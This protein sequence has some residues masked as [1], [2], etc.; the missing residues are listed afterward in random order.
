MVTTSEGML[1]RVTKEMP[2]DPPQ[3]E[4]DCDLE[5]AAACYFYTGRLPTLPRLAILQ[6]VAP[7]DRAIL[8]VQVGEDRPTLR[9][10]LFDKAARTVK[11]LP[12]AK[13]SSRA[14]SPWRLEQ[15]EIYGLDGDKTYELLLADEKGALI[16]LREF[17]AM[18]TEPTSFKFAMVAGA[19]DSAAPSAAAGWKTLFARKPALIF[20]LGDL[21][22]RDSNGRSVTDEAALWN[23]YNDARRSIAGFRQPELIPMVATWDDQDFGAPFPGQGPYADRARLV[24]ESFFPMLANARD[25]AEGPGVAKA[26]KTAGHTF[27]LLDGRTFREGVRGGAH[28]GRVQDWAAGLV[29]RSQGPVWL[30]AGGPW[31]GAQAGSVER[32]HPGA[33]RT[34]QAKLEQAMRRAANDKRSIPMALAGGSSTTSGVGKVQALPG[35]NYR[36]VEI[37]VR[38][39]LEG[40]APRG[41]PGFLVIHSSPQNNGVRLQ[42][43]S[44]SWES[45]PLSDQTV[46]LSPALRA[47]K[48]K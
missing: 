28:L 40:S 46:Q 32:T 1:A 22:L 8:T 23:R 43:E 34:L 13:V 26:V 39:N 2:L 27:V 47:G 29:E 41:A 44:I 3:L 38:G 9:Y 21:V 33:L 16:D 10:Y 37:L 7:P 19:D 42:V 4:R 24:H 15:V 14:H 5:D 48:K 25:I 45:R 12:I 35:L 11:P 18:K 6:G 17:R 30:M 31:F 20:G 36:S